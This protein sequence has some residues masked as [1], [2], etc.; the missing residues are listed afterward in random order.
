M[1]KVVLNQHILIVIA[2][3]GFLAKKNKLFVETSLFVL[4]LL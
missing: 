4:G 2:K 1:V 3:F